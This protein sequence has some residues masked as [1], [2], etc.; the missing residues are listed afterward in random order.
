MRKPINLEN[1]DFDFSKQT[2][3]VELL[4]GVH[5]IQKQS[6]SNAVNMAGVYR[7]DPKFS[8]R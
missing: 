7:N 6:Q 4:N 1:I 3:S 5:L 8:D 2:L